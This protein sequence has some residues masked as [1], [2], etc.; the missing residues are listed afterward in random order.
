MDTMTFPS[1]EE[2][3]SALRSVAS[4]GLLLLLSGCAAFGYPVGP[5]SDE[6]M[7]GPDAPAVGES[8]RIDG[9]SY[10]V[11]ASARGYRRVGLASWYGPGFDGRPTSSGESFDRNAMTAAHR[12]LPLGSRVEVTSLATG[13]SVVVRINDRGPFADPDRRIIDLSWAAA[14]ELGIVEAGTAEVEVRALDGG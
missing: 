2:L 14:R 6:G 8:Y 9:R 13:R 11:M 4:V 12:T 3:R 1:H 5:G 10:H 7:S